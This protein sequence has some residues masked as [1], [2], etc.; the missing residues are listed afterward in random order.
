MIAFTIIVVHKDDIWGLL[1][2]SV[3]ATPMEKQTWAA[4]SAGLLFVPS[5]WHQ[6][7]HHRSSFLTRWAVRSL[8]PVVTDGPVHPRPYRGVLR[9]GVMVLEG[10]GILAILSA[11]YYNYR[12]NS[13]VC[14]QLY[15]PWL[16]TCFVLFTNYQ[17]FDMLAPPCSLSSIMQAAQCAYCSQLNGVADSEIKWISERCGTPVNFGY[18][19]DSDKPL[20]PLCHLSHNGGLSTDKNVLVET[21]EIDN[22]A[23]ENISCTIIFY[24]NDTLCA[25]IAI[26]YHWFSS[27]LA[28]ADCHRAGVTVKICTG[29]NDLTAHLVKKLDLWWDC[30]CHSDGTNDSPTLK[31]AHVY[32]SMGIAGTEV[33]RRP[34]ISSLWTTIIVKVI[35]WGWHVN[36][37]AWKFLQLQIN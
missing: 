5:L 8:L 18:E 35:M 3:P 36:N 34:R 32:F 24:A 33:P 13:P 6:Q 10:A 9:G 26:C 21:T 16:S 11:N 22:N 19:W 30:W 1:G 23:K 17:P 4:L 2:T 37:T 12:S 31:A 15:T 7:S 28:V 29:D 14:S 27:W 25:T 20:H